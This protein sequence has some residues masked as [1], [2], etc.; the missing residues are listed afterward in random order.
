MPEPEAAIHLSCPDELTLN[1]FVNGQLAPDDDARVAQHVES[2]LA[3]QQLLDRL[4]V[5]LSSGLDLLLTDPTDDPPP[6]LDGYEMLGLL[7]KG[8]MGV[9]WRMRELEFDRD[10]ALKVM[11]TGLSGM[12]DLERRFL[13]EARICARLVHPSIVT[14]HKQG[15]L[16]DGR[17]YYVMKFVAGQTLAVL[18]QGQT[19][20]AE[21]LMQGVQVFAQVCQAVG[22]AHGQGVIHRDLKPANVMVGAFGEVQ[23]MDWGVAKVLS[24]ADDPL[25]DKAGANTHRDSWHDACIHTRSDSVLGTYAYMSPEQARGLIEEVDQRS[26]VFGLGAILCEILTGSVPYTARSYDELRKQVKEG[27]LTDAIVRLDKSGAD[28]TLIRLAK[29]CLAKNRDERPADAGEVAEVVTRYLNDLREREQARKRRPL[30]IAL[31]AAL[32]VTVVLLLHLFDPRESNQIKVGLW[33]WVGYAPLVVASEQKLCDGT[34]LVLQDVGDINAA[35][36]L[37]KQGSIHACVCIVDAHVHTRAQNVSAKVVLKLDESHGADAIVA[38]NEI[39]TFKQLNGKK[40]AF[41]HQEPPH[42]L[43]LSLCDKYQFTPRDFT[44]IGTLS[45]EDATKRFLAGEVDAVGTYDPEL[46]KA[47]KKGHPIADSSHVPGEIVDILSIN[48]EYLRANPGKVQALIRGWFRAVE[49]LEKR[50][51]NAIEIACRFLDIATPEEYFQMEKG[52]KFSSIDDNRAFF[53]TDANGN[54]RFREL[55]RSSQ[56]RWEKY[57]QPIGNIDPK[58]ADASHIFLGMYQDSRLK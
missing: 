51:P 4:Q 53:Q 43:F 6:R 54:S 2:C 9:V 39:K 29:R 14:V 11:K 28:A 33:K 37:L 48:E 58:D 7:G 22:Y 3:C 42:F 44:T 57:H 46:Q 8:G 47:L 16:K 10:V 56:T 13:N 12:P 34:E 36:P 50:D 23:V 38:G 32:L 1:Q 31:A 40:I 18:L 21:C 24:G 17:P 15:R 30:W 52:M 55:M 20:P 49:K 45:V 26:D 35:R 27:N 41:P 19:T 5:E 25:T